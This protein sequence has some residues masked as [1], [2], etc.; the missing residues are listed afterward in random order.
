MHR[1]ITSAV[2]AFG[3]FRCAM[4]YVL[5][6]FTVVGDMRRRDFSAEAMVDRPRAPT[7]TACENARTSFRALSRKQTKQGGES[8][9]ESKRDRSACHCVGGRVDDGGRRSGG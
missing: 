6:A 1:N 2:R 8:H 9:V 4:W 3:R 7:A 5:S